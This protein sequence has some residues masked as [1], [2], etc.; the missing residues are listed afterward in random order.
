MLKHRSQSSSKLYPEI[1]CVISKSLITK[2]QRD[3][4][5]KTIS[6]LTIPICGDKGK[7]IK[8]VDNGIR[9]P[10]IFKKAVLPVVFPLPMSGFVRQVEFFRRKGVFRSKGVL[11]LNRT[12]WAAGICVNTVIPILR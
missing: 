8:L 12:T 2:Y 4:K 7:Q 6:H 10:A 11:R 1:P 3:R 9:I 5:C